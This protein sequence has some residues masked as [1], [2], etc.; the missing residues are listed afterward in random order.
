ME[1][2]TRQRSRSLGIPI[3]IVLASIIIAGAILIRVD[4]DKKDANVIGDKN[5]SVAEN[6]S[7]IIDEDDDFVL[8]SPSATVT[9]VNFG[10]FR[11]RFCRMFQEQIKPTIMEKY[12][13]TGKIK[14]VYRDFI[15]MG[16]NSILAAGGANCAGEQD[17]YWDFAESLHGEGGGAGFTHT[18]KSLSN[19]AI[20][21]GLDMD[22]F[23]QCLDLGEYVEEIQKDTADAIRAGAKGTPVVFINN[24]I[25]SGLNP[26][27]EYEKMIE[28]ELAK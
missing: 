23:R 7:I 2:E 10:D 9:F 16:E 8:G 28:E 20:S 13:K 5:A 19:I 26:L 17:K 3:A 12:V 24:R 6:E 21:I 27:E 1:M 4:S 22:S 14:Y 25:I 18:K 15:T 11:C